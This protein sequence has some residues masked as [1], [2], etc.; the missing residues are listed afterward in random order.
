MVTVNLTTCKQKLNTF[1]NTDEHDEE[2]NISK[3]NNISN[4]HKYPQ[5]QNTEL[6]SENT[7]I[8]GDK[9]FSKS[10]QGSFH[11]AHPMFGNNA[12]TQCVA[13]CLAGLAFEQFK[14]ST[15]WTT[16]D[17]NRVLTTGDELYTYLQRSSSMH[18]R[19]LLVEELPQYLEC[20]NKSFEFATDS[21][22]ATI[23][24][25]SNEEPCY[26]DFNAYPLFGA[27]QLGF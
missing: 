13:N 6:S 14:C 8:V 10:I 23:I 20:Y 3:K 17:M 15:L 2:N 1:K 16:Q 25:L 4:V 19:Y 21:T 9:C 27:L 22:L 5:N 26:A 11:Q 24:C 12:G 7:G 18:H